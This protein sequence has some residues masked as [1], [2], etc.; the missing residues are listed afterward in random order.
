LHAGQGHGRHPVVDFNDLSLGVRQAA[1]AQTSYYVLA[2]YST[3]TAN[4]GKFRRVQVRLAN[5]ALDADVTYRPG[6]YA[7]KE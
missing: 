2:F 5:G 6:Y 7:D 1:A 4:D 3:H